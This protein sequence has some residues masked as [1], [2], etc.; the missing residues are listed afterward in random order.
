MSL[1]P[2]I[3]AFVKHTIIGASRARTATD[4]RS[5]ALEGA[6]GVRLPIWMPIE[7]MLEKPQRAYVVMTSERSFKPF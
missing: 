4:A 2:A 7:A 6:I 5:L 3:A 1:I